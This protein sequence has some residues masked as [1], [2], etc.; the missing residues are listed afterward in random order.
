MVEKTVPP[1]VFPAFLYGLDE[2][3]CHSER[4]DGVIGRMTRIREQ[5]EALAF[6]IDEL[7]SGTDDVPDEAPSMVSL[8]DSSVCCHSTSLT[9][10]CVV[11]SVHLASKNPVR[12]PG[13]MLEPMIREE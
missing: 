4:H 7:E 5:Y 13:P 11:R 12:R 6:S 1:A 10:V 3:L 9:G 2:G 8:P